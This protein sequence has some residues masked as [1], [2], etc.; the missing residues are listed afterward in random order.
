MKDYTELNRELT[1]RTKKFE[2]YRVRPYRDSRG[3]LT[4]GY[5]R[6]LTDKPYNTLEI[7]YLYEAIL[8]IREGRK[9]SIHRFHEILL[10]RD[11][12]DAAYQASKL[13]VYEELPKHVRQVIVD[14]VFNMG[15]EKVTTFDRM[16]GALEREDY[17]EAAAELLD[18]N[19]AL[20]TKT[21]AVANARQMA[22]S[23][24]RSVSILANRN[25]EQ[26]KKLSRYL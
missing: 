18:S 6:N 15:F 17:D 22:N 2:G 5:G 8:D 26:H 11:L 21:R 20:Q 16:L 1:E 12:L 24:M 25:P 9:D 7:K 19:Y 10:R 14:L 23:Y 4:V 3:N 13:G